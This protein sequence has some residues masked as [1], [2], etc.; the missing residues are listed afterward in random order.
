MDVLVKYIGSPESKKLAEKNPESAAM[1]RE[2]EAQAGEWRRRCAAG[3]SAREKKRGRRAEKA[4]EEERSATAALEQTP[5]TGG[6]TGGTTI[7]CLPAFLLSAAN[8]STLPSKI[9]GRPSSLISL[10]PPPP[11]PRPLSRLH[12]A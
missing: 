2:E 11:T 9:K 6:L 8:L 4:G 10:S 5:D 1:R 3:F 7:E 12:S